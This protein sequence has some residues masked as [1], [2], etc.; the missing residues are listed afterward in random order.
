MSYHDTF[1][2]YTFVTPC[3]YWQL[4]HKAKLNWKIIYSDRSG[5]IIYW[6]QDYNTIIEHTFCTCIY[7]PQF[8]N[9]LKTTV[10][11]TSNEVEFGIRASNYA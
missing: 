10:W 3:H 5:I 7:N 8:E 9:Y 6:C 4:I 2:S 1:P 11:V